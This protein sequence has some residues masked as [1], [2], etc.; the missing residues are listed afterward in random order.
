MSSQ[1]M[2]LV[3]KNSSTSGQSNLTIG[4]IAVGGPVAHTST[5]RTYE[6]DYHRP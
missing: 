2:T 6:Y 1:L 5:G 4:R 3:A